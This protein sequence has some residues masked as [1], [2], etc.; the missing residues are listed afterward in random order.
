MGRILAG[1]FSLLLLLAVPGGGH[2]EKADI[3]IYG[4]G[5][6]GCAAAHSSAM[7]APDKKILLVIPE[8]VREPGGLGTV[9]GQNFTDIR[10]WKNNLVTL[11]SFERWFREAGQ[12]YNNRA[13]AEIINKDLQQFL[14]LQIMYSYDI[15]HVN[16]EKKRIRSIYICP[17]ERRESG[18]VTWHGL[19][20]Q[21]TADIFIDASDDGRLARLTGAPLTVGRQ[22]W[23]PEYLSAEEKSED[24]AHQQAATLM[25]KATGIRTPPEP[26]QLGEW[27]FSRDDKGSWGLAGGKETWAT[28][29]VITEFNRKY[30]P[31]GFSIKPVNAAQNGV[32]SNEWWINTLLVYNVDGRAHQRDKGT[33]RYPAKAQPNHLNTDQAWLAAR[34]ILQHP[35]FLEALRQFKV[36]DGRNTYGFADVTLVL[37]SAGKPVVGEVMYLRET[38]HSTLAQNDYLSESENENESFAVTAVE[39]QHAGATPGEGSDLGNYP[40]R[41]GLGYYMMDINAYQWEDLKISGEYQWPVTGYVRP[42][43][44]E[45]G[46]EPRNPVYLPFQMLKAQ[47]YDNMLLAGNAVSCSAFA[48]AEL[49]VLP[50][51]AVM[52]D[53]AGAAAARAVLYNESIADFGSLQIDWVRDKLLYLGARL[54]K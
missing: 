27:F 1:V 13:M 17:I 19:E 37:D 44:Q 35:D 48:W 43:W 52:G 51:L 23:P 3:V 47:G 49:R 32:G 39:T 29:P 54:E 7:L 46:G 2:L 31:L 8:P 30:G 40:D 53:A 15:K 10:Y 4:G 34:N 12:F 24:W 45:S 26:A 42:D 6:A 18:F 41:I 11:G 16:A 21:V 22:D 50:N 14:N 36:S 20:K 38:V 9:G 25:F 28:N 5:F 33:A